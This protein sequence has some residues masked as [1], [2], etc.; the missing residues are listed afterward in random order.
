M[1]TSVKVLWNTLAVV[2]LSCALTAAVL[3]I[4][5]WMESRT[6]YPMGGDVLVLY[7]FK[8]GGLSRH[9]T[10]DKYYLVV[11]TSNSDGT[12][13]INYLFS[14]SKEQFDCVETGDMANCERNQKTDDFTGII[15]KIEKRGD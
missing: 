5:D 11:Q 6:Y 9:V 8:A 1:R 14:C 4:R 7:K 2:L 10:D 15:H 3:L 13:K 12:N